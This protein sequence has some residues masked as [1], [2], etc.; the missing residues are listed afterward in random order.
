M[1]DLEFVEKVIENNGYCV[2]IGECKKECP[3]R[4]SLCPDYKNS[5]VLKTAQAWLEN[6][7]EKNM[8]GIKVTV[9]KK[10]VEKKSEYP[11]IK[12]ADDLF[13]LFDSKYSGMVIKQNSAWRV[14]YYSATW[15]E[16][17]FTP[18]HGKIEI[19]VE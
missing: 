7:K 19:E 17:K 6:Y 14:G 8:D 16:E 15:V 5:Y 3:I 9:T 10:A 18:F 13:V 12:Q 11:C 1:T 2:S 4:R